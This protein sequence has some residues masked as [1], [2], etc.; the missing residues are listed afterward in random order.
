[1][2]IYDCNPSAHFDLY[3]AMIMKHLTVLSLSID[4]YR[5]SEDWF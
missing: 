2:I 4:S 1:M 3:R 5:F